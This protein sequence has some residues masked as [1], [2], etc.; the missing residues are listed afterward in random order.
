MMCQIIFQVTRRG[1]FDF[2][3]SKRFEGIDS[4]CVSVFL[5]IL[6][7]S[8]KDRYMFLQMAR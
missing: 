1:K 7:S 8:S 5:F 2:I 4:L 3:C 6:E